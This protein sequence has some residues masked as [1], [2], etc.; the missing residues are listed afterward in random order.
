MLI[1]DRRLAAG[2]LFCANRS[3]RRSEITVCMPRAL[4]VRADLIRALAGGRDFICEPGLPARILEI[5][6][7]LLPRRLVVN[8]MG[9]KS[10]RSGYFTSPVP[11]GRLQEAPLPAP[12]GA[13]GNPT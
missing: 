2:I 11:A 10:V 6:N 9:K 7:R 1:T 13:A 5:V 3:F 8:S 4:Q 12:P